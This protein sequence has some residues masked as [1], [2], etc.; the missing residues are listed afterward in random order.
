[1]PNWPS[2]VAFIVQSVMEQISDCGAPA[3]DVEP[4]GGTCVGDD[5]RSSIISAFTKGTWTVASGA[6][7][8]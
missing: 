1:M 2:L 5:R 6:R 3:L 4:V 8:E 7:G